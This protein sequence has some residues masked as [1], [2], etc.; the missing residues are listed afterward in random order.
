MALEPA[1]LQILETAGGQVSYAE[2][3]APLVLDGELNC[4]AMH[5]RFKEKAGWKINAHNTLKT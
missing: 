5:S 2:G 4:N 3:G 1:H